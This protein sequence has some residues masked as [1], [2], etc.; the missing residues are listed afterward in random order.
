M[1]V[2]WRAEDTKLQ[3]DVALKFLPEGM[4]SN[5]ERLSGFKREA[6]MLAS[7]NDSNVAA[8]HEMEEADT[9]TG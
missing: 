1:G 6:R 4:A 5:P 3:R 8:I 2:V 9:E 7:L